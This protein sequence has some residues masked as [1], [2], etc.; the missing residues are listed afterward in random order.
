M[1]ASDSTSPLNVATRDNLIEMANG[2]T[3]AVD[4]VEGVLSLVLTGFLA[5]QH[6]DVER[7]LFGLEVLVRD[8][9]EQASK[10]SA[11]VQLGVVPNAEVR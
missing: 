9:A 1:A 10:L 2:V 7:A 8:L 5:G 6:R 11:S 4:R 3:C